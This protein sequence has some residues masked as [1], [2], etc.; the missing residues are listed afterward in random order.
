MTPEKLLRKYRKRG[1][2]RLT[3]T[4]RRK[5]VCLLSPDAQDLAHMSWGERELHYQANKWKPWWER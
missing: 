4:E 5:V 1:W 3:P 2:E